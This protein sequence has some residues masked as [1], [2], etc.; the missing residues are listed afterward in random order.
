MCSIPSD[1]P[2][3][4][5]I[6]KAVM[7]VLPQRG[8]NCRK[9]LYGVWKKSQPQALLSFQAVFSSLHLLACG[10]QS[11]NSGK[12]LRNPVRS[13]LQIRAKQISPIS[14][15]FTWELTKPF[16]IIQE[17]IF[18]EAWCSLMWIMIFYTKK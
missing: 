4:Q 6:P 14:A 7:G 10:I 8:L 15:Q 18:P 1:Q 11:G 13:L 3:F 2:V 5:G 16:M 12:A 9:G 17:E